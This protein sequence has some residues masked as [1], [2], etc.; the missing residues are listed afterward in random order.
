M[1]IAKELYWIARS[2]ACSELELSNLA[3]TLLQTRLDILVSLCALVQCKELEERCEAARCELKVAL[4]AHESV[5]LREALRQQRE[6]LAAAYPDLFPAVA[7][8]VAPLPLPVSPA[9][10]APKP[11]KRVVQVSMRLQP[12]S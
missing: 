12:R 5:L 7:P 1:C 9:P 10:K 11:K 6:C 3:V 4:I 8:A 2:S